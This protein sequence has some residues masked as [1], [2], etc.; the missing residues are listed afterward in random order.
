MCL[1][2]IFFDPILLGFGP[3]LIAL[4]MRAD[5]AFIDPFSSQVGGLRCGEEESSIHMKL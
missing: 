3:P 2:A 4:Q 5:D 1:D